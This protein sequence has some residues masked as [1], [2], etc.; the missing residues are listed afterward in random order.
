MTLNRLIRFRL[1]LELA[2]VVITLGLVFGAPPAIAGA[3]TDTA[4][5]AIVDA[6]LRG[7]ALGA[8][9]TPHWGLTTDT[10]TD[11]GSGTEPAGGAYARVSYAASMAN[12]SGTQGGASTVASTGTGG[13]VS[14]NNPIAWPESSASWGTVQ[15]VRL[16]TASSG[17]SVW[18]CIDLTTPFAVSAAGVTVRFP[19]GALT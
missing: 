9:A 8:P 13:T 16:Y 12:W 7:Q 11:S 3:L 5:N 2:V 19:A 1:L 4:E 6:V 15:A 14:N 18:I 10:C 17:G